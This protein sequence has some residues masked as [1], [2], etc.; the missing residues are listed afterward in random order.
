MHAAVAGPGPGLLSNLLSAGRTC[1]AND[2]LLIRDAGNKQQ[3]MRCQEPLR[4]ASTGKL[5]LIS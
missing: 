4:C 5:L 1:G 3:V 2:A